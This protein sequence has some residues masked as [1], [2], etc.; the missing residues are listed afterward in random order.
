LALIF[1]DIDSNERKCKQNKVN[2]R[3]KKLSENGKFNFHS[4]KKILGD[5]LE[6][7]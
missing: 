2:E 4:I 3:E 6:N 5:Y 7:S 1:A